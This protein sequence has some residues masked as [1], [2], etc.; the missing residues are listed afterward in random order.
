LSAA[1][2]PEKLAP[3]QYKDVLTQLEAEAP[4]TKEANREPPN[5]QS[6]RAL[7][8]QKDEAPAGPPSSDD[9]APT[10]GPGL[11]S[12]FLPQASTALTTS[13]VCRR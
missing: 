13:T 7:T 9:A 4:P 12:T 10:L 6:E 3:E 5:A 1:I 11:K 2:N 8:A